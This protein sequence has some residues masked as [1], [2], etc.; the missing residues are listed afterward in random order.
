MCTLE[1]QII[2]IEAL[3]VVGI[4]SSLQTELSYVES[5]T[6]RMH[7]FFSATL[8]CALLLPLR[9]CLDDPLHNVLVHFIINRSETAVFTHSGIINPQTLHT[10]PDLNLCARPQALVTF[11]CL[12]VCSLGGSLANCLI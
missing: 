8:F 3:C 4:S 6:L 12:F 5:F 2:E 9:I 11:C 7:H 10:N 1:C